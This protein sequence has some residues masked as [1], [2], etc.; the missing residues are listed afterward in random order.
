[1]TVFNKLLAQV[2]ESTTKP[3]SVMKSAPTEQDILANLLGKQM[4]IETQ[5]P[6]P[7]IFQHIVLSAYCFNC[8]VTFSVQHHAQQIHQ[9]ALAKFLQQQQSNQMHHPNTHQMLQQSQINHLHQQQQQSHLFSMHGEQQHS[10]VHTLMR[11]LAN[12]HPQVRV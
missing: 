4:K 9:D 7:G 2:Q 5:P 8:I 11:D 10:D 3:H 6:Q 1:M 12:G